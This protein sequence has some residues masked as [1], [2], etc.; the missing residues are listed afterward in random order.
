VKKFI[1]VCFVLFVSAFSFAEKPFIG[2]SE[3]EIIANND[4]TIEYDGVFSIS[5][6]PI[7]L[8]IE[9]DIVTDNGIVSASY[10]EAVLAYTINN[11]TFKLKSADYLEG[12]ISYNY[13][14][15]NVLIFN[16]SIYYNHIVIPEIV[17]DGTYGFAIV[18][19][20]GNKFLSP[21]SFDLEL[22]GDYVVDWTYIFCIDSSYK[23]GS[24]NYFKPYVASD[25]DLTNNE[26]EVDAGVEFSFIEGIVFDA[27][28][29]F[30]ENTYSLSTTISY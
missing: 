15:S 17:D 2:N 21:V 28:W 14:I 25:L 24:D 16:P 27:N 3:I 13:N 30:D 11:F 23:I 9:E 12:K 19:S 8:S 26:K 7:V 10:P 1:F 20:K 6:G 22:D 4:A 18:L 5:K 29:V